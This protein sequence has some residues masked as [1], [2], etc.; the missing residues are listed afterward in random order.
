MTLAEKLTRIA[1][2]MLRRRAGLVRKEITIAD[3][4]S[5]AYLEGGQGDPLLL[6]H[7]L[8]QTKII[9]RR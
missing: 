7:G 5:Y 1:S 2:D 9:L 4:F 8:V 6:L 3:E